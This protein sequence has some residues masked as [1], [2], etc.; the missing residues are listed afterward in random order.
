MSVPIDQIMDAGRLAALRERG[1]RADRYYPST[2]E[3][4]V[5]HEGRPY[6][7][8]LNQLAAIAEQEAAA[9]AEQFE[10]ARRRQR[11][12]ALEVK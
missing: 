1:M 3:V 5:W 8:P 4:L 11:R 7:Y 6:G 12:M 2:G 10:P 9:Q